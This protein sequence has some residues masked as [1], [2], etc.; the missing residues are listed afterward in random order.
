LIEQWSCKT[1]SPKSDSEKR[2]SW[3]FQLS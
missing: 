1:D 3:R 2:N